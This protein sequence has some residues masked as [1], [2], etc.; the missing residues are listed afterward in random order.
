MKSIRSTLVHNSVGTRVSVIPAEKVI[1]LYRKRLS[2]SIDDEFE[3]DYIELFECESSGYKFYHPPNLAGGGRL[4]EQLQKFTWYYMPW[5]WEHDIAQKYIREGDSILEIGCG[6]ADFLYHLSQKY[7]VDLTGLE[8]NERAIQTASQKGIKI[9]NQSIQE[10]SELFPEKHDFVCFFQV[11]EHIYNVQEFISSAV[12]SLRRGGLLVVSV[13]NNESF[14]RLDKKD[15]LN[16]PPHHMGLWDKKSLTY[17]T[18]IFPL[19]L[20]DMRNEPLQRYHLNWY[21]SIYEENQKGFLKRIFV[22]LNLYFIIKA[23]LKLVPSLV[24]GH[25][26]LAVYRKV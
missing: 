15:A 5:K 13:P 7:R 11:L 8:L 2:I 12:K 9:V 18:E 17:L 25:T 14:I 23:M 16:M 20:L 26:I 24:S 3:T 1:N 10:Y 6:N 19:E 22:K 21:M 4:Y